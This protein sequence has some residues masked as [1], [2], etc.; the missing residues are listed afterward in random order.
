MVTLNGRE[1]VDIEVNGVDSTDAWDFSDA[2]I[3]SATFADTGVALTNVEIEELVEQYPDLVD[4][5]AMEDC[6]DMADRL[7]YL[8]D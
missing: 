2:Y 3:S 6:V 7:D 4:E 1:V 5:L 8:Y